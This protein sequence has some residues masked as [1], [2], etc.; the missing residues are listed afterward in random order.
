MELQVGVKIFLKNHEGKY[1]LLRRSPEKYSEVDK[2]WDIP[3]GRINPGVSL[4]DNLKREVMEETGL[5]ITG[6]PKLLAAQ[7]IL[8]PQKHI[9]RLTY[10]GQSVGEVKL[11][12]EHNEYRWLSVD[13]VRV[14]EPMDE[15]FKEVFNKF[16]LE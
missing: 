15:Y 7:D 5:E 14:L 10:I 16:N 12:E 1:L 11:S 6:E 9:V 4:I 13:E 2:Y 8:R 3:G